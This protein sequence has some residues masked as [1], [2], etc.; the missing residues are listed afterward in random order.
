M[1]RISTDTAEF[2]STILNGLTL[3]ASA[4]DFEEAAYALIKARKELTATPTTDREPTPRKAPAK[5]ASA[6]K[7]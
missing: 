2:L 7:R 6:R 3:D 4:P 5:K 1:I